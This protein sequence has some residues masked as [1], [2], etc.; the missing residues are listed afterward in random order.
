MTRQILSLAIVA[1]LAASSAFAADPPKATPAPAAT[2]PAPATPEVSDAVKATYSRSMDDILKASKPS[3]WRR[4]DPENT[5]YL[6]LP[7]GRVVIELAPAFAPLHAQNIRTMVRGHYFDG[8]A[9]IRSQDNWVT[10]WGDPEEDE[11]KARSVGQAKDKLAPEFTAPIAAS[12]PFTA[13]PDRDGYA[14]QVGFSNDFPV[15]RDPKAGQ[16]WLAHCYGALGVARGNDSDSG[17][18]SGLY[19]VIGN[20]PRHLDRNIAVVGRVVQGMEKLSALPRGTGPLGFYEKAEERKPISAMR[21]AADVPEAERTGLEILRSDSPSFAAIA[22]AR[23]NRH[24][25]WYVAPAGHIE[26]CNVQIPV[27]PITP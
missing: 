10:Q 24:D 2:K 12:E 3:E 11:T 8:L 23:R 14:M 20:A 1:A 18:G 7:S 5:L 17:N 13:L 4:L 6:E 25:A 16:A 21:V 9:I 26:L 22:E 19:V 27:R 15:G